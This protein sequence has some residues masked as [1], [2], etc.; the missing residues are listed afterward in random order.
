MKTVSFTAS[1]LRL[2]AL[3]TFAAIAQAQGPPGPPGGQGNLAAQVAALE[4]KVAI[5]EPQ[6]A[7]L[8]TNGANL[9]TKLNQ[10]LSCLSVNGNGDLVVSGCDLIIQNGLGATGTNNGES[11]WTTSPRG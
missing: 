4:T 5:L 3:L 11:R 7:N 9:E 10:L 6:V 2:I 1:V 8:E